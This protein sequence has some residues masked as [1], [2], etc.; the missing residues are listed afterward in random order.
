MTVGVCR[1]LLVLCALFVACAAFRRMELEDRMQISRFHEPG[2]GAATAAIGD[3]QY[4]R[5]LSEY[6]GHP[7]QRR[8]AAGPTFDPSM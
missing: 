7:M 8:S 2:K 4:L 6:F 1:A 3:D 5:Y